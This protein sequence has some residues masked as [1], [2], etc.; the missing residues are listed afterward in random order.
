LFNYFFKYFQLIQSD[1]IK[2]YPTSPNKL[3]FLPSLKATYILCSIPKSRSSLQYDSL[4]I[5][6]LIPPMEITSHPARDTK[7]RNLKHNSRHQPRQIPRIVL[8]PIHRTGRDPTNSPKPD[9]QGTRDRALGRADDVILRKGQ[10]DGLIWLCAR[11]GEERAEEFDAVGDGGG[12][13]GEARDRDQ[14]VQDDEGG[15][16]VG[17][18]GVVG[19]QEGDEDGEDVRWR[20]QDLR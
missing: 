3:I 20:G 14:T 1:A 6:L 19:C 11:D 15:A 2:P 9:L 12:D 7:S 4:P 18:V 8:L 16:V 17:A 13:E 10:G 5:S